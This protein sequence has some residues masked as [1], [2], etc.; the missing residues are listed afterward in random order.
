MDTAFVEL[1]ICVIV[2]FFSNLGISLGI[3]AEKVVRLIRAGIL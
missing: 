1:S 2:I 3:R